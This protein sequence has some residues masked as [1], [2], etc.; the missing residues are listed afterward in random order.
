MKNISLKLVDT[1]LSVTGIFEI[2][3]FAVAD[4]IECNVEHYFYLQ[5]VSEVVIGAPYTITKE[6]IERFDVQVTH[7]FPF[8][9]PIS[10]GPRPLLEIHYEILNG[11]I[12]RV[13]NYH[14]GKLFHTET[15]P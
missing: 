10:R 6:L 5:P 4:I 7:P 13:F 1:V 14:L 8:F 11:L 12:G 15:K 9:R 2:L 3:F